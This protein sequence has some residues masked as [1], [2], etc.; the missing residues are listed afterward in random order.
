MEGKG[1]M[2]R[3]LVHVGDVLDFVTPSVEF[4]TWA[5]KSFESSRRDM[6]ALTSWFLL[7]LVLDSTSIYRS[8]QVPRMDVGQLGS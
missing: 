3:N 5:C 1:G 8:G 6:Y 2:G 4:P 7:M